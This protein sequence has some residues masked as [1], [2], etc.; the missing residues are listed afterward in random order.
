VSPLE[1]LAKGI[2]L[3]L[4]GASFVRRAWHLGLAAL[5]PFVLA[6]LAY[7]GA[8]DISSASHPLRLLVPLA[9]LS[10]ALLSM[11]VEFRAGRRKSRVFAAGAIVFAS[12]CS[13]ILALPM[14]RIPG[15]WVLVP[16]QIFACVLALYV[17]LVPERWLP[18]KS[19]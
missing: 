9:S 13:D 17:L 15:E 5:V 8:V 11:F 2:L 12:G 1:L 19:S 16:F 4:A 18:W 7:Y 3:P 14:W 10:V 6:A